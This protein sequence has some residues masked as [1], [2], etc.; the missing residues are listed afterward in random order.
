MEHHSNS[1]IDDSMSVIDD[2]RQGYSARGIIYKTFIVLL[3]VLTIVNYD[4]NM[5]IGQG[6]GEDSD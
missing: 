3:S 2:F 6:T 5:F 1:I 4:H